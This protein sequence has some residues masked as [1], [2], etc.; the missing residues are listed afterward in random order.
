ML[1]CKGTC[2]VRCETTL[3]NV[4][5]LQPYEL[6]AGFAHLTEEHRRND[7]AT[8][9]QKSFVYRAGKV[10]MGGTGDEIVVGEGMRMQLIYA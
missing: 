5:L 1:A 8:M 10:G 6:C 2:I 7:G 3:L 9:V 4:T